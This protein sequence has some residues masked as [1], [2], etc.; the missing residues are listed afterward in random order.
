MRAVA[1]L[2]TLTLLATFIISQDIS[3]ASLAAP[4]SSQS[5]IRTGKV[6]E[7]VVTS[8]DPSQS[9]ALY[10]PSNYTPEKSWPLLL[11]LDPRA[12]GAIPVKLFSEAAERYGWIVIGSNNSRNGPLKPSLEAVSAIHSDAQA[13]FAIDTRRMYATGFSG[14]AR[15]AFRI[16]SL[17]RD[18]LAGIVAVG[19][20][21]PP[22]IKA[23]PAAGFGLFGIAGV[24]DFNF[25][26]MKALD[27]AYARLK[28]SHRFETFDGGHSWPPA[29]LCLFALEWME[30]QAM[31]SARRPR[32]EKL[33]DEIFNRQMG[34]A[35]EHESASRP[36]A[37]HAAFS[38]IA[39]DF[40]GLRDVSE[41]EKKVAALRA[42]KEVRYG[43]RNDGDDGQKQRRL[44]NEILGH[45]ENRRNNPEIRM[46][47]D[48]DL[49]RT[50]ED[51]RKDS[52]LA[53][54]SRERRI[55]RRTLAQVTAYFYER[56]MNLRAEGARPRDVV[57][58][59]EVVAEMAPERPQ[60]FYDLAVAH[61]RN[62]DKR[63]TLAA[64]RQAFEKGFKDVDAITKEPAFDPLRSDREFQTLV[65]S[66]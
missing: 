18:C 21:Y 45:I 27:D 29:G 56:A 54:D 44:F 63:K 32:D 10:L 31:R 50:V 15:L 61:A 7:S 51:L 23:D 37:A 20:G 19:A 49:R 1:I 30:V 59:L 60:V 17:C 39:S 16:N 46:Q 65:S 12:R 40:Q 5:E 64:L 57:S 24:D 34:R 9:Y 62:S 38:A 11:C 48:T 52:Q 14:G 35:R 28:S 58:A 47:A 25:P 3:P 33:L 13:R 55:A 43:L 42:T 53:V 26:E 4:L 6:I 66:R 36:G 41:V 2:L 8:R 22:D